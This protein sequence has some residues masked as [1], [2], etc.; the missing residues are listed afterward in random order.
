MANSF[1]GGIKLNKQGRSHGL[2]PVVYTPA[3]VAINAYQ[4]AGGDTTPCIKEGEYVKKGQIIAVSERLA[5]LHAPVS[6]TVVRLLTKDNSRYIVIKSDK[7]ETCA[8]ADPFTKPVAEITAEEITEK[9]RTMGVVGTYSGFPTH[10]KIIASRG[11]AFCL[12]INCVQSDPYGSFVR[13]IVKEHP[14]ELVYGARILAKAIGVKQ[15][16]FAL[17][18]N[19][20]K[21]FSALKSV[22]GEKDKLISVTRL[23]PKYPLGEERNLLCAVIKK[24]VPAGRATHDIGYTVFSAETVLRIYKACAEGVPVTDKYLTVSGEKCASPANLI[25]PIGTSLRAVADKCGGVPEDA[26]CIYGSAVNG[27]NADLENGCVTKSTSQLIIT[28]PAN[29]KSF[30]C[31]MCGKC[32]THCPMRIAPH[33]FIDG[34]HRPAWAKLCD[35]CGCCEYI[36]PSEIKLLDIIEERKKEAGK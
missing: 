35:M 6:G 36:C 14:K 26:A 17:E 28:A 2:A 27:A 23:A 5:Y 1:Y 22:I 8:P 7:T 20:R 18:N 31:I 13:E 10:V 11:K 19:E 4:Q 29:K 34:S 9:I 3:A 21:S 16:I 32:I 25:V 15:V 33:T 12:V 30:D 24:E